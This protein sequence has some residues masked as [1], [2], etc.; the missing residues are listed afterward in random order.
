MKLVKPLIL[1]LP[2]RL[3]LHLPPHLVPD[4]VPE[5]Q[6]PFPTLLVS[7]SDSDAGAW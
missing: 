7:T 3:P 1:L 5:L 2:L 6:R 4:Q